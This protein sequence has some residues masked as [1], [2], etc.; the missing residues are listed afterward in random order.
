MPTRDR[1]PRRYAAT[2]LR[3]HAATPLRR[4]AATPLRR[5]AATPL[6]RY[7]ATPLRR[8]AATPL[9]RYAAT[10]LRRHAATPL[11]RY[12]ATPLRRYAATPLRRYAA[13]P[14]RRHV[15][16]LS[17]GKVIPKYSAIGHRA[18]RR[19][20][21]TTM[22]S[23]EPNEMLLIDA[24]RRFAANSDLSDQ[25][26]SRLMGVEVETFRTWIAGTANPQKRSLN[27]IRSF[28]KWHARNYALA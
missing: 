8:H 12:A 18:G 23:D 6:R 4:Y 2:P 25:R 26:I 3:R 21:M 16:S 28:L 11:R 9:R 15:P 27:E 14:L 20:T 22:T 5:Y 1:S 13:T 17:P 10:P 7:A 19:D 24:L